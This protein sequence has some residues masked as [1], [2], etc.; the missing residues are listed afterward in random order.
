M[1]GDGTQYGIERYTVTLVHGYRIKPSICDRFTTRTCAFCDVATNEVTM[2]ALKVK[3]AAATFA[4]LQWF[5][6]DSDL[7]SQRRKIHV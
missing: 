2:H 3:T 7:W 1:G 5:T 6:V 4:T